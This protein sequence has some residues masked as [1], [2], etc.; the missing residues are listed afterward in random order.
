MPPGGAGPA[1][2]MGRFPNPLLNALDQNRDGE[3]SEDEIDL[4]VAS[5][6]KLDR[7]GDRR[8]DASELRPNFPGQGPQGVPGNPTPPGTPGT[9]GPQGNPAAMLERLNGMD[10]NGDGKLSRDELPEPLQAM[11]E[12]FDRN[13]DGSLD[14][15]EL[16]S[17]A[18][19]RMGNPGD[20]AQFAEQ[21]LRRADANGDGKLSGEELPPFVRDRFEALDKNSDGSLD[22]PELQGMMAGQRQMPMLRDANEPGTI[23][24]TRP[25]GR[26]PRPGQDGRPARQGGRPG[27]PEAESPER[28]EEPQNNRDAERPET[29]RAKEEVKKDEVKADGEAEKEAPAEPKSE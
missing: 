1:G 4:A 2:F 26:G 28:G 21:M 19:E 22:L 8:L 16:R 3:L 25:Q 7:N 12:R 20:P 10:K 29:E 18:R 5:L 6:K 24:P 11:L 23:V 9:P 13:T 27:R 14:Q 17:M 15:E